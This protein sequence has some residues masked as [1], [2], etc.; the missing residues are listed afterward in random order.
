MSGRRSERRAR[1]SADQ[2][3]AGFGVGAGFV[4]ALLDE[5]RADGLAEQLDGNDWRLTRDGSHVFYGALIAARGLRAGRR[6]A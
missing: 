1:L 5:L 3:A 4:R 2:A 6:A